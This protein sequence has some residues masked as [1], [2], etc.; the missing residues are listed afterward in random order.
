MK[1]T[2]RLNHTN[3]TIVMDRTFAKFAANTMSQEYAH[4][5]RV[6]MDYPTYTVELRHIKK[7][8]AKECY[9]GLTY[10]Y[11][12][13]YIIARGTKE[14]LETYNEMKLISECHSKAFRYP[15]IKAWFLE[16]FPEIKQ[17][18]VRED[19]EPQGGNTADDIAEETA[20]INIA[21]LPAA[22]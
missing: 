2:L 4:L 6:R 7:A 14:D 18:G 5:Q 12:K 17:F 11:M 21:A 16:R 3:R 13:D 15:T 22:S 8:P 1:N 10:T 19:T 20:N 9:R